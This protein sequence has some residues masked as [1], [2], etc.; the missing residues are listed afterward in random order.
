VEMRDF[1][2]P[3]KNTWCPGCNNFGILAAV[4]QVLAE[5]VNSGEARPEEIVI[6]SGVG[7]HGKISDYIRVNSF[8]C[9]H[10]RTVPPAMGIKVA[11]QRL[12]IIAF[13]G[14]GDAYAEGISHVVHAA[15]RNLNMTLVVHDNEVFALTTSQVTPTTKRGFRTK[16]APKGSFEAPLNPLHLMLSCGATFVARGFSGDPRH[17]RSILMEAVRHRGFSFIDV[18]QECVTFN[19]IKEKYLPKIYDLNK[20]GHD[21]TNFS[22]AWERASEVER[23][24]IGIFYRVERETYEKQLLGERILA[25]EKPIPSIKKALQEFI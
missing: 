6:L 11:N 10:G 12:K 15:R 19:P 17:L 13:S 24:P 1:D 21:V 16:S 20:E 7:C 5:L 2:S 3:A 22:A 14:D 4:K 25:E 8:Y 23:I 18:I 9:L